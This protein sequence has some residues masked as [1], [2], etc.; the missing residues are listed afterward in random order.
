MCVATGCGDAD[1]FFLS[2]MVPGNA[3]EIPMV[4]SS[5]HAYIT[6]RHCPQTR[7]T[8]GSHMQNDEP[9][10]L[11]LC[12]QMCHRSSPPPRILKINTPWALLSRPHY[13]HPPRQISIDT[14]RDQVHVRFLAAWSLDR[15]SICPRSELGWLS[16]SHSQRGFLREKASCRG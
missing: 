9:H 14:S 5:I 7:P 6:R 2:I 11:P 12:M 1:E 16:S 8:G 13:P 15:R 4:R 3:C 10:S